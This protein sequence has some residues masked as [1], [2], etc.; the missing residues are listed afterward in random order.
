LTFELSKDLVAELGPD[1]DS[2]LGR[3]VEY[4]EQHVY[5]VLGVKIPQPEISIGDSPGCRFAVAAR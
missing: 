2:E 4:V 1:A 3:A 5:E